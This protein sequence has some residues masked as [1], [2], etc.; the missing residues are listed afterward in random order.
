MFDFH[1]YHTSYMTWIKAK[2]YRTGKNYDLWFI[3]YKLS[4]QTKNQFFYIEMQQLK[5]LFE[6]IIFTILV[7]LSENE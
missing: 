3:L 5:L 2:E 1:F 6:L 7:I 4:N